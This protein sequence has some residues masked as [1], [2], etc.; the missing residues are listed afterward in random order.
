MNHLDGA[1][2]GGFL[3]AGSAE[4]VVEENTTAASGFTVTDRNL[5]RYRA[6]TVDS[7]RMRGEALVL[8]GTLR[9]AERN[10]SGYIM[11]W[12]RCGQRP[13]RPSP[14]PPQSSSGKIGSDF[15]P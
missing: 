1:S 4:T 10:V 9:A 8:Q 3:Q 5:T 12:R 11:T 6:Q 2:D 14:Y 15:P 7:A 13:R